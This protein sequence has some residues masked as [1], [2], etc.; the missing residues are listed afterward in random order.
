[1]VA[2]YPQGFSVLEFDD[3]DTV[4]IAW[5]GAQGHDVDGL[6]YTGVPATL[7]MNCTIIGNNLL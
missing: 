1:V 4:E 3:A 7:S 5:V 2:P 6:M